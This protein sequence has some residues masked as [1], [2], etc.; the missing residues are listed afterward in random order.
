[1]TYGTTSDGRPITEAMIEQIAQTA[2]REEWTS[3]G[4]L[5]DEAVHHSGLS[6]SRPC[7]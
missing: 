4:A 1:V 2:E 3:R 5:V 6:A 7:R